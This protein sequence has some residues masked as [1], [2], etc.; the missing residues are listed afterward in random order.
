MKY[1]ILVGLTLR[2]LGF[3]ELMAQIDFSKTQIES[4]HIS[5]SVYLFT[6][7]RSLTYQGREIE[8][9]G[10]F[11]A[12]V[13]PDGI[14]VVDNGFEEVADKIRESLHR[15]QDSGIRMLVNTHWHQDHTGANGVLASEIPIIA[16]EK[17][18]QEMMTEKKYPSG[19]IIPATPAEALP[20]VTFEDSLSLYFNGEEIKLIHFPNGHTAGDVVVFFT[21]S[22]VIFMGDTFNGRLFPSVSGD[23]ET[24]ASQYE[25]LL[26][27]LPRDV[28]VVSG[29]RA[30]ATYDDLRAY[31][32]MLVETVRIVR[33]RME[34]AK[35][36]E[37]IQAEGLP[38]EWEA[39]SNLGTFN[40]LT[41]EQW[42]DN[43]YRSLSNKFQNK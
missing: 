15:I 29:H 38:K 27:I 41:T 1:L 2:I 36:L 4:K 39:W 24:Y 8:W 16:H 35:C 43:I 17:T 19:Y 23:V 20:N 22:K 7:S 12:S 31:H 34:V 13:G 28:N 18:R 11:C 5:G 14:L 3:A 9:A 26:R 10:N 40:A 37:E 30:L 6:K 42:I 21:K 32:R 25:R 33:Q